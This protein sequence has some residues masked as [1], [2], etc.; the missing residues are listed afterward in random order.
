MTFG[1]DNTKLLKTY[2]N[3]NKFIANN[4]G[5]TETDFIVNKVKSIKKDFGIN[6][7]VGFSNAGDLYDSF[8]KFL[9]LKEFESVV[10][11]GF[12][13]GE[14]GVEF[15][16]IDKLFVYPKFKFLELNNEYKAYGGERTSNITLY[17]PGMDL[18]YFLF[19]NGSGSIALNGGLH[20]DYFSLDED[21]RSFTTY[22]YDYEAK[23]K[24]IGYDLSL[25]LFF[26]INNS[27]ICG[28][29]ELGFSSRP[30][31]VEYNQISNYSH[32]VMEN[33]NF[34]GFFV[35]GLIYFPILNY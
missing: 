35:N 5:K 16:T 25:L 21:S 19:D 31:N 18:R 13:G 30:F 34:G 23:S 12:W 14:I 9:E 28:G 17:S 20:Y 24:S 4:N 7:A 29:L 22:N 1:V 2:V 32:S 15:R 11:F 26:Q 8:K 33:E 6:L 27:T 10:S 3:Q